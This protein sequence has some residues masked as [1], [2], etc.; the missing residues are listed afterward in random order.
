MGAAAWSNTRIEAAIT[1]SENLAS[2][3]TLNAL[4]KVIQP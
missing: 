4:F 3:P 2:A 1:A